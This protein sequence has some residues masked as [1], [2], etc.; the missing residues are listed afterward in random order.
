MRM[1]KGPLAS[2]INIPGTMPW[3]T[4]ATNTSRCFYRLRQLP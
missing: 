2:F 1:K 4:P 3:S